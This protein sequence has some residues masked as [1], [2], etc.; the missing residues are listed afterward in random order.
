[1]KK[2]L[3]IV[4]IF[5]VFNPSHGQ[6][7]DT[8]KIDSLFKGW[9][10]DSPGGAVG[11]IK[12]GKL[13]YSKGFGLAH[14]EHG[15][16]NKPSTLFY[17]GSI[18]KQFVALSILLLE[19][20]K[21]LSLNDEIQTYLDGF[22]RYKQPIRI[23]NLIHHTS[24]IRDYFELIKLRGERF[25]DHQK[26]DK[27]YNLIKSQ[28][29]TKFETGASYDYSN[30]NYFLLAKII[31]KVSGKSLE[32]F[33]KE[34]I[35]GPLG[36]NNTKFCGNVYEIVPNRAESYW[37]EKKGFSNLISRYDLVGAGGL[38]STIEDLFIWDENLENNQLGKGTQTLIKR[39]LEE[40]IL[41]NGEKCGYAFGIENGDYKGLI[42]M[43]HGGSLA[44][45]RAKF[46]R[47]PNEHF[48]V[49][50]L[51]NRNDIDV[52]EK[53][54][55]IADLFLHEFYVK[56]KKEKNEREN[57]IQWKE[58]SVITL[59]DSVLTLF[60][61]DYWSKK[62][63]LLRKI[64]LKDN[65]LWYV[66]DVGN[67]TK[68]LPIN[69]NEFILEGGKVNHSIK[70]LLSEAKEKQ[71]IFTVNGEVVEEFKYC[72]EEDSHLGNLDQYVGLYY[73]QELFEAY[74]IKLE[75]N[76][77]ILY[78]NG[79]RMHTITELKNGM[80]QITYFGIFEFIAKN[81]SLTGFSLNSDGVKNVHFNRIIYK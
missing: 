63:L 47:F 23:K 15:I 51:A 9:Y 46:L 77:L 2:I 10:N 57:E 35:F 8:S 45:F 56:E 7:F 30:S 81:G 37:K 66:R 38:Y 68:L 78:I 75:E 80:L 32:D 71:Y 43:G 6:K 4:F 29:D 14:M 21:K 31:E 73:S 70:F 48:T 60:C 18:A 42:T 54:K 1:M 52:T 44:G 5:F 59:T 69:E 64:Y 61:G 76:E 12:D 55:A 41:N 3:I 58:P 79:K 26:S 49:I 24:G 34:N 36:M 33:A 11:I 39:L 62:S 67:E 72:K 25:L 27:V 50:I 53:S 17:L 22:P 13:I 19:E 16:P 20:E 28:Y 74:S 65:N 40:G